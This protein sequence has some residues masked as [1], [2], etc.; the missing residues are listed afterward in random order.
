MCVTA[1]RVVCVYREEVPEAAASLSSRPAFLDCAMCGL[2]AVA[3][4]VGKC[5]AADDQARRNAFV[6]AFLFGI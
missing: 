3:A 4:A 1:L 2:V 5:G 6:V